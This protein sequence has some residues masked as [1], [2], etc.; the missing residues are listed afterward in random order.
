MC[1][2]AHHV[3]RNAVGMGFCSVHDVKHMHTAHMTPKNALDKILWMS[4]GA[5]HT[6]LGLRLMFLSHPIVW[7]RV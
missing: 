1:L 2:L 3:Q 5:L 7:A 4:T 6:E